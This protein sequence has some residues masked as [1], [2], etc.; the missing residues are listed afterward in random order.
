MISAYIKYQPEY[1]RRLNELARDLNENFIYRS[2][3]SSIEK[4]EEEVR[5]MKKDIDYE[6]NELAR[7][8]KIIPE[9]KK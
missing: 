7:I 4:L 3:L 2:V 6:E 5:K 8:L 9:Q 1:F